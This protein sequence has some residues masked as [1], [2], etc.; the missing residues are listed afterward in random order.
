MSQMSFCVAVCRSYLE[1]P[2]FQFILMFIVMDT[3]ACQFL[4]MIGLR[5]FPWSQCV[6]VLSACLVAVKKRYGLW[7]VEIEKKNIQLDG[8]LFVSISFV[9]FSIFFIAESLQKCIVVS[10]TVRERTLLVLDLVP[11][12]TSGLQIIS[13][14]VP[15]KLSSQTYFCLDISYL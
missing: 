12:T 11:P 2:I 6:L 9:P 10:L 1:A 15:V 7:F 13:W 4:L 3:F 5:L 14:L 8:I